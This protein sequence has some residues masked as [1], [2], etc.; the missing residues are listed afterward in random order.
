EM[1][2]PLNHALD[3]E[4]ADRYKVEPYVVAAD[5]YAAETHLG[6]GGWTWYTG[7]ASWFYQ[8]AV[9]HLLGL[10]V[11]AQ[12]GVRYLR[13]DPC[14]PKS[15]THYEMTYRDAETVYEITVSNPRGVNRGVARV[16]LDGEEVSGLLIPLVGDCKEHQVRVTLLGG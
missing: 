12:D 2:N 4:S 15:W 5:V 11:V 10:W 1:V 7:S 9:R 3:T 14:V 16:E 13:I 6:R 8:V